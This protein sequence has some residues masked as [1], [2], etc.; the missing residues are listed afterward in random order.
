MLQRHREWV[1]SAG[2]KHE[3]HLNVVPPTPGFQCDLSAEKCMQIPGM[4]QREQAIT[5][6]KGWTQHGKACVGLDVALKARVWD[7][8]SPGKDQERENTCVNSK[9]RERLFTWTW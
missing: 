8:E 2:R 4:F 9:Q 3:A 6:R 1:R 7:L 5:L